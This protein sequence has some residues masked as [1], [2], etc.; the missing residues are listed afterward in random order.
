VHGK[1]GNVQLS[2][3]ATEQEAI[4]NGRGRGTT[5]GKKGRAVG[6]GGIFFWFLRGGGLGVLSGSPYTVPRP[7]GWGWACGG[8]ICLGRAEKNG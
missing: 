3:G 8:G 4:K 1:R 6:G 7:G 2:T 5:T